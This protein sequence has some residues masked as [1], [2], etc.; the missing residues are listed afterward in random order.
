M[1]SGNFAVILGEPMRTY[2]CTIVFHHLNFQLAI[3]LLDL[4]SQVSRQ[5]SVYSWQ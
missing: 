1:T 5:L 4:P 2:S 3:F